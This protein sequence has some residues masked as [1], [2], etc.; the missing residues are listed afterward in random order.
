MFYDREFF[1]KRDF[2][3]VFLFLFRKGKEKRNGRIVFL[4]LRG[5]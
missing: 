4:L 5:S 2:S 1:F 3:F